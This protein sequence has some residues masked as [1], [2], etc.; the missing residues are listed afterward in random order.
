MTDSIP[1]PFLGTTIAPSAVTTGSLPGNGARALLK[2]A[3]DLEPH[4][5]LQRLPG[6]SGNF[7]SWLCPGD[8]TDDRHRNRETREGTY[9]NCI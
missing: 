3:L 5:A 8:L 6:G 4:L 1:A 9:L 2:T 7:L